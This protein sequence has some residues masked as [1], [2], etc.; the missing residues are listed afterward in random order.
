MR[1]RFFV[2]HNPNAGRAGR[3]RYDAVLRRLLAHGAQVEIA[4]TERHGD[5]MR[6]TAA[7]AASGTFDAVVAA[8]G[9]GTAHD[10]A[11]GLVGTEMPL[12]LIPTGTAN[13]FAR[14]L[15]L[16]SS[17]RE[18]ADMLLFGD[19]RTYPL[20]SLDGRPFLFVVGVGFDAQAV[21]DFEGAGARRLGRLGFV[22]PVLRALLSTPGTPLRITTER[23]ESK[24]EWVIV[25]RARRYAAGLLLAKDASVTDMTFHVVRFGGH[26]PMVRIRQLAALASGLLRHDPD[27]TI[28]TAE[29]I[30]I[31]GDA[32]TPVQVDGEAL[33]RLPLEIAL[34]PERLSLIVPAAV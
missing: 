28:E 25:T 27:V 23:G 13:V 5:G 15:G 8:G 14:E 3:R 12:G 33:G 34:H 26:G 21:R 29:Q 22:S 1:R 30:H 7:A 10:A 6:V 24:A 19:V 4:E 2:L 32:A 11:S 31:E 17:P 9:D 20:G 18:L 16:P